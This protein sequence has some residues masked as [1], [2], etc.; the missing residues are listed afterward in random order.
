MPRSAPGLAPAKRVLQTNRFGELPFPD[1]I[2]I[3]LNS[4]ITDGPSTN[5]SDNDDIDELAKDLKRLRLRHSGRGYRGKG[6]YLS[7]IQTRKLKRRKRRKQHKRHKT[8][9]K[10]YKT[11]NKH[12]KQRKRTR[13][14]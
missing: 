11:R 1:G 2:R 6:V 4:V 10:H 7:K 5:I 12:Y 8:R 14:T 3:S 13:K 9:N